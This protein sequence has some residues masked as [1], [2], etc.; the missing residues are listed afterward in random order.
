MKKLILVLFIVLSAYLIAQ[1]ETAGE[2]MINVKDNSS[3]PKNV[4]IQVQKWS[5]LCWTAFNSI[6][7]LTNSF[8]GSTL[9]TALPS[10]NYQFQIYGCWEHPE[11]P[12]ATMG[13]ALYKITA[14]VQTT[15]NGNYVYKDHFYIDY[16]TS[17]IPI[18][19]G[20][21]YSLDFSVYHGIFRY[22]N[23]STAF[24]E[25]VQIWN[26]ISVPHITTELEPLPPL[27]I[28]IS[29][30][31]GNPYLTW[32]ESDNIE[33]YCTGY[34]VYRSV[35]SG[36]G[37]P[38][39]FAKIATVL[40]TSTSYTDYDFSSG[41]PMTAYYKI[42]S[43]NGTRESVFTPIVSSRVGFYKINNINKYSYRLSQNYPNPFNP[44]TNISF[45][46]PD[47]QSIN[48]KVYDALGCEI[49]TLVD[50]IKEA[51]E[52]SITFNASDLNSGIYFYVMR[53]SGFFETKKLIVVK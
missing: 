12:P 49:K 41:G 16:R 46:L 50:E 31:A 3:N 37:G 48:I 28:E 45:S 25:Q 1:E 26:L 32:S 52:H 20:S 33:D 39:T 14:Y 10:S 13:L 51:G 4:A 27:D 42:T 21:D 38:G 5:G 29:S 15:T 18:I 43:I 8:N 35:V 47:R 9:Y 30:P 22:V 40:K 44:T 17:A 34:C 19:G 6:H 2:L 53:S 7:D 24:P 36:Q 23:T 11:D